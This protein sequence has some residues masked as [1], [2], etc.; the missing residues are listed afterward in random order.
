MLVHLIWIYL[1]G[2]VGFVVIMGNWVGSGV[3]HEP[4]LVSL[5]FVLT[6]YVIEILKVASGT[7]FKG[8]NLVYVLSYLSYLLNSLTPTLIL[9]PIM[10]LDLK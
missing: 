8:G 3:S 2:Q 5:A 7:Y 4:S 6:G 10:I 9:F 1:I